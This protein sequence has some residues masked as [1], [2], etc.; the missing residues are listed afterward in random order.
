MNRNGSEASVNRFSW[1]SRRAGALLAAIATSVAV[2]P[3]L[4]ADVNALTLNITQ[5]PSPAVY[6]TAAI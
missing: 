4:A 3:A 2:A 5:N 6:C 1:V